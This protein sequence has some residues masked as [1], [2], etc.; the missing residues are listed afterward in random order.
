MQEPLSEPLYRSCD[1][2]PLDIFI[3]CL[4]DGDLSGL[5][6][7]DQTATWDKIY[8]EYCQLSQDGSYNE[9]F[10]IMKEINDLRAK[11]TIANNC[12]TFL[13]MGYDAEVVGVLNLFALRCNIGP[14]DRGMVLINKLNTIVARIKKWF[15]MLAKAEKDL[16]TIRAKSEGATITRSYFDDVLELMSDIKG[17][18]IEASSITVSRFCRVLVKLNKDAL[19][20]EADAHRKNR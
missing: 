18:N 3:D 20:K 9:V 19:K 2:L 16:E 7:G 4:I 1:K 12:I 17:R 6:P 10:E 15:P 8:I 11:I 13:Q 14:D 5:G